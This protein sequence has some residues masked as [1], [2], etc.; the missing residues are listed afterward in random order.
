[1]VKELTE[2]QGIVGGLYA[3]RKVSRKKSGGQSTITTN[4]SA[5]TI[6]FLPRITGQVVALADKLDTLSGC[7]G[8]GH[9]ANRLRIRSPCAVPLRA[10]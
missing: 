3:R 4:R 7:F 5:W 9:D 8:I 10:S 6:P 1:M 2:L